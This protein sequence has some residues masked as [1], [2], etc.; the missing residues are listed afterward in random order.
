M[1]ANR[2]GSDNLIRL[3]DQRAI[4]FVG[5]RSYDLGG[6][7]PERDLEECFM[8]GLEGTRLTEA[9]SRKILRAALAHTTVLERGD[10]TDEVLQVSRDCLK[11]FIGVRTITYE[12][13][14]DLDKRRR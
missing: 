12:G 1:M 14:Q 7:Q 5:F 11:S 8:L 3:F 4:E 2:L 13:K 9:E 6:S 10:V